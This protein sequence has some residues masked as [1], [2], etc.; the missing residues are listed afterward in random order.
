MH[1]HWAM[2]ALKDA[3][4]TC[5][6]QLITNQTGP[7]TQTCLRQTSSALQRSQFDGLPPCPACPH[8][9]KAQPDAGEYSAARMRELAGQTRRFPGGK[10]APA[11][12]PVSV[13]EPAFRL[14]GGFKPAAAAKPESPKAVLQAWLWPPAGCALWGLDT[15]V[16]SAAMRGAMQCQSRCLSRLHLTC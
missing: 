14:K 16:A 8:P 10:Q 1:A 2:C 9:D 5:D 15:W 6:T 4:P 13:Q 12:T 11:A 7:T 3:A